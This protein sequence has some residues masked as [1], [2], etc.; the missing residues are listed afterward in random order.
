MPQKKEEFLVLG[1][2]ERGLE[3]LLVLIRGRRAVIAPEIQRHLEEV[4]S[5]RERQKDTDRL[6]G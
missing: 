3:S 5:C 6:T 2:I 4:L 1:E